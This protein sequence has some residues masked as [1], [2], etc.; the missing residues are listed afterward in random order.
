LLTDRAFAVRLKQY[1]GAEDAPS[2][3]DM[4]LLKIG[5]HFRLSNGDWVIVARD[6]REGLKLLELRGRGA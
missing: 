6:D 3:A 2:I 1:F 4:R 5:R